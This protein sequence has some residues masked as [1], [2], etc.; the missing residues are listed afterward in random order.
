MF[1]AEHD[2]EQDER[3]HLADELAAALMQLAKDGDDAARLRVYAAASRSSL[4]GAIDNVLDALV[5]RPDTLV[6]LAP[7]ARWLIRESRH[8]G[9]AKLGIALLGVAGT[10]CEDDLA[11]IRTLSAHGEFAL[12]AAVAFTNLLADPTD[13]LWALAR[14]QDGWGK[15]QAV[16]RLSRYAN[17]RPDI[18][19][20]LIAEGCRNGVM[21]DYLAHTCATAGDLAASLDGPVDDDL[22]AGACVIVAAL[23]A[24]GGPVAE[25]LNDYADG[26]RAIG[27][28]LEHLE[29]RATTLEQLRAVVR[30]RRWLDRGAGADNIDAALGT[31]RWLRTTSRGAMRS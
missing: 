16:E 15:I 24:G 26:P 17:D 19:R 18:Q 22:L 12:F 13:E 10:G 11:L 9:P 8:R 21:D 2:D 23:S 28:L 3:S 7:H 27:L 31:R 1:E 6:A 30:L 29:T 25:E 14:E 20:W 4:L 5:Q